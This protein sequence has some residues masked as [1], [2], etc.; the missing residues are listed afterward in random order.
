M[1]VPWK[2]KEEMKKT[3]MTQESTELE[4]QATS[5]E[6]ITKSRLQANSTYEYQKL[7]MPNVYCMDC[8]IKEEKESLVITYKTEEMKPLVSLRKGNKLKKLE[9]LIQ[10]GKL[11]V[12]AK[13]Y[14]FALNPN[15]LYFD[16][17]GQLK[18][19]RRDIRKDSVNIE[20]DFLESYCALI[21]SL[22]S[23]KYSYDDI[24][25][26]GK[27]LL[28]ENKEI[29]KIYEAKTTEEVQKILGTLHQQ[30]SEKQTRTKL[31]VNRGRYK[32]LVAYS[33]MSMLVILAFVV[34]TV[35]AYGITIPKR[36]KILLASNAYIEDDY[37][38]VIDALRE[39]ELE[40]L[41]KH[42]KYILALAYIHSQSI[43]TFRGN[44]KEVI[45][46]RI[47]YR[48]DEHV[49]NYWIYLGRLQMDEAQNLAMQL[50]DNQLLLY[51]YMQELNLVEK[52]QDISGTEKSQRSEALM[53]T[54][55]DLA[56]KLGIDYEEQKI[57]EQI[58]APE[59][60]D[61]GETNLEEANEEETNP[62][63]SIESGADE[64]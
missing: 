43:D 24:I 51:A 40:E 38:G 2:G 9:V 55:K 20:E 58:N 31:Q 62:E 54:I 46:S 1:R 45:L 21:G 35:Y 59:E 27:S 25:K 26:G 64:E 5:I 30:L 18:I 12:L 41:E 50:A 52:D 48:G 34:V 63:N 29:Q 13:E 3:K 56:D 15:N 11:E 6:E 49:L 32:G 8:E 47:S 17:Y 14:I 33:I 22:L 42:Q 4:T 7:A 16:A 36:E 28:K 61:A 53:K 19:M 44:E 37:V 57:E 39:M 23:Q 10:V 60:A